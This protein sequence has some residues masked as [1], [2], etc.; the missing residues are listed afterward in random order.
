MVG[1]LVGMIVPF[2]F[3]NRIQ[4]IQNGSTVYLQLLSSISTAEKLLT[5]KIS[6]ILYISIYNIDCN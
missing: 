5:I 2:L 6:P 3:H 4:F 1:L